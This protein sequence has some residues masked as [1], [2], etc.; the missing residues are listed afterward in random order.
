LTKLF[1]S[2]K[3]KF[4]KNGRNDYLLAIVSILILFSP[5]ITRFFLEESRFLHF[6]AIIVSTILTI[7]VLIFIVK[8]SVLVRK[9]LQ[10][11]L[12]KNQL[13]HLTDKDRKGFLE[14]TRATA[15]LGIKKL[16]IYVCDDQVYSFSGVDGSSRIIVLSRDYLK[17]LS[18]EELKAVMLHE[19]CHLRTDAR[20]AALATTN[21]RILI[22]P[23]FLT[24]CAMIG[25]GVYVRE[26]ALLGFLFL[27]GTVFGIY[28]LKPATESEHIFF[29]QR[30]MY[31]DCFAASLLG[32]VTDLIS[33]LK[34][35]LKL[36]L[37]KRLMENLRIAPLFLFNP[38]GRREKTREPHSVLVNVEYVDKETHPSIA[39]RIKL[40]HLLEQFLDGRVTFQMTKPLGRILGFRYLSFRTRKK[41]NIFQTSFGKHATSIDRKNI[42]SIR[43]IL[44][45][46]DE[47][48]VSF[49]NIYEEYRKQF[50]SGTRVERVFHK[51]TEFFKRLDRRLSSYDDNQFKWLSIASDWMPGLLTKL[52]FFDFF[53]VCCVLLQTGHLKVSLKHVI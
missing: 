8:V 24:L 18:D 36:E 37:D 53:I 48:Q 49:N 21:Y 43:R 15:R 14:K 46:Y 3:E 32:G 16:C 26:V 5:S 25:M 51:I 7:V 13:Y 19:L 33:V 23:L 30:E 52:F 38:F 50:Q 17:S 28:G 35:S 11:F 34:L 27:F 42:K 12:K 31:A 1:N 4:V 45:K 20:V 22:V 6:I 10:S 47:K 40:L 44:E 9:P 2:I 39:E 41:P 29:Q